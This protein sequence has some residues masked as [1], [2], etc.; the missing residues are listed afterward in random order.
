MLTE[1]LATLGTSA[2][3]IAALTFLARSIINHFFSK[4]IE[5]YK[6]NLQAETN[7]IM[8]EFTHS[9]E[10]TTYEHQIRYKSL[11]EKR[12][13]VI[14]ETYGLLVDTLTSAQFLLI[15]ASDSIM[16]KDNMLHSAL[17]KANEFMSFYTKNRIYLPEHICLKIDEIVRGIS[18][19]LE[20]VSHYLNSPQYGTTKQEEKME[21]WRAAWTSFSDNTLPA[22]KLLEDEL[23]KLLGDQG[24]TANE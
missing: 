21:I 24:A 4:G 9:L 19:T 13:E 5:T 15:P 23:R 18:I 22:K 3:L 16:T 1:L 12:A 6:T 20:D 11:H 2:I 8:L 14:A 17:T 10:K 7:K